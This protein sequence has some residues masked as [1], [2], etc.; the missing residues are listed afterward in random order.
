MKKSIFYISLAALFSC[1]NNKMK[2]D[3]TFDSF[4]SN[5]IEALW[6]VYP[7]WAN[8]Q[9]YHKY[10]SI[11]V[12]PNKEQRDKELAFCKTYMDSLKVFDLKTL[13]ENDQIDYHLI[14]NQLESLQ[15]GITDF[16]GY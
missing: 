12:I 3:T 16:K 5:F 15:W 13:S 7:E 4:K 11:L 8:S 1:Q 9:G 2:P 10:D 14:E 6:K